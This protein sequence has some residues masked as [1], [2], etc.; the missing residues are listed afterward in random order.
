MELKF[1]K[2]VESVLNEMMPQPNPP[3]EGPEWRQTEHENPQAGYGDRN[4]G[5]RSRERNYEKGA[6]KYVPNNVIYF[7]K[8]QRNAVWN[9]LSKLPNFEKGF[10]INAPRLKGAFELKDNCVLVSM[11]NSQVTPVIRQA[12]KDAGISGLTNR[13][14]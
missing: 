5:L 8:G 10:G 6:S 7:D 13:V 4:A 11:K 3:S 2:I 14:E 1:D 9:A 12:L